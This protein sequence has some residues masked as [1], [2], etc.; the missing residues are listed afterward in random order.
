MKTIKEKTEGIIKHIQE[1]KSREYLE[2]YING[3]N[4]RSDISQKDKGRYLITAQNRIFY[5]ECGGRK[6]LRF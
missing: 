2:G 1:Q 6:E 3:L 5:L 4:K